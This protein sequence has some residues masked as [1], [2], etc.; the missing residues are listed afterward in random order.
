LLP[1]IL[2]RALGTYRRNLRHAS[3][4]F[5][6][7]AVCASQFLLAETARA[8]VQNFGQVNDGLTG[9]P[10]SSSFGLNNRRMI[11]ALLV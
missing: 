3:D 2:R 5:I 10:N 9:I 7:Q 8:S 6:A 11:F 1:L 4:K